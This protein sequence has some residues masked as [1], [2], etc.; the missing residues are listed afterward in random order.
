MSDVKRLVHKTEHK[1]IEKKG[2]LKGRMEQAQKDRE[3]RSV[4]EE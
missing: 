1:L 4:N 2:E 3:E